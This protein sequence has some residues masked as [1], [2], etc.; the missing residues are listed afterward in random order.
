MSEFIL[1]PIFRV[2]SSFRCFLVENQPGQLCFLGSCVD[3]LKTEFTI[4]LSETSSRP[5]LPLPEMNIFLFQLKFSSVEPIEA[6][7]TSSDL[8]NSFLC[9]QKSND[10]TFRPQ[11]QLSFEG[12]SISKPQIA[13][14]R[15][16]VS[17][18]NNKNPVRKKG[19]A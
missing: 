3:L 7:T 14:S 6:F 9:W 5:P 2:Y 10:T 11:T 8:A 1:K 17:T 19:L 12:N 18:S 15:L 16:I 13:Y 4:S